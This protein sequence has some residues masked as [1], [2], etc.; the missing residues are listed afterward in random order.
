M[1]TSK[2]RSYGFNPE[3]KEPTI[4]SV[5]LSLKSI[6]EEHIQQLTVQHIALSYR[7]RADYLYNRIGAN[8][9]ASKLVNCGLPLAPPPIHRKKKPAILITLIAVHIQTLNYLY[10]THTPTYG[11]N[12]CIV[13]LK[14]GRPSP[15]IGEAPIKWR[16]NL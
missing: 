5:F 3:K 14:T 13:L 15:L 7:K 12:C 9:M 11:R 4:P 6:C 10:R 8:K 2:T 1:P 16:Q